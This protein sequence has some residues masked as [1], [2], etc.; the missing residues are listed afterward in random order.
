MTETSRADH[1]GVDLREVRDA[2]VRHVCAL[3]R[4]DTSNPPGNELLV[5]QY[6]AAEL[7]ASGIEHHVLESAPGR[8]NL[9]ARV[10]GTGAEP[11]LMLLAHADVVGARPE[12]WT[13]PPFS[14]A[15]VDGEVWG[16]GTLDMKGHIASHLVLLQLLAAR[17]VRLSGDVV[18]VVTADEEAGS[19]LGA[20]WLWEH[21]RPLVEAEVA[22]NE[23]GGQRFV[24]PGGPLYTVQVAE[25]GTA[26]LRVTARGTGGHAS[27]PRADN[28]VLTLARALARLGDWAA[29]SVLTP[30]TQRLL[31]VLRDHH[32][33]PAA[34]ALAALLAEPTWHAAST[35]PV[36]PV[37]RD[38]VVAGL[39]NTA[40]P[41]VLTASDRVNVAP[42]TASA[43][44]DGRLVP[45]QQPDDWAAVVQ[46]VVGDLATVELVQGRPG[47]AAAG[48]DDVLRAIDHVLDGVEPGARALPYVSSAASDARA[49]PGVRVLGFFPSA[50]DADMMRMI[51]GVD[52]RARISDLLFAH[53]CLLELVLLLRGV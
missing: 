17:D 34:A 25:K 31:A 21:H 50:S 44:L 29:P 41:T 5:A 46:R 38:Y 15:V 33:P 28:A 8:A 19:H 45:G 53:R 35:L 23:G 4:L 40:V 27:I 49:L 22:F 43:V 24:T 51:H 12:G 37:L 7:A 16:R 36:D 20:H 52:E 26:R 14:G 30:A 39:H 6:L 18:L 11:P 3:V 47:V 48:E 13:H 2:I 32:E 9:V 10:P 1:L 42:A